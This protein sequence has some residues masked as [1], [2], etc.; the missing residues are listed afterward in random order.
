[1][2]TE[3]VSERCVLCGHGGRGA[4]ALFHMTHGVAVWLC[5]VHGDPRF[6]RRKRGQVFVE[7]LAAVWRAAGAETKR[8]LAALDT[9]RTRMHPGPPV[10][11]RPGS[12][13]WPNL[14][15]M[16]EE[17]FAA[18][19]DPDTVIRDL[20]ARFGNAPAQVP[21]VRTM[22]RWHAEARWMDPGA[23]STPRKPALR[24]P[25]WLRRP[26]VSEW[27]H[28]DYDMPFHPFGVWLALWV[29]DRAHPG[30]WREC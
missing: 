23:P 10:R 18:G 30:H 16:A 2:S 22:H 11:D 7:R 19:E 8:R 27:M 20:R 13:S 28:L 21:S 5:R 4:A 25:S 6:L 12:Y 17:R 26:R 15:A 9:H 24:R 29:D 3:A 1:M 14:R